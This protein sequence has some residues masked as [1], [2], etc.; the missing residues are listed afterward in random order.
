MFALL[1]ALVLTLGLS[2]VSK[3]QTGPTLPPGFN[4]SEVTSG[5]AAADAMA[6]A[7]DGRIFVIEKRGTVRVIKNG[8]LLSALFASFSARTERERGM[9]GIALDPDFATNHY[10]YLRYTK[11]TVTDGTC[12]HILSR[13]TANG[14][15]M[16]AGSEKV[17]VDFGDCQGV[18]GHNAGTIQ[19]GTDGKLYTSMGDQGCC[20]QYAQSLTTVFGKV[21]RLNLDGTIPTDNPFYN[22]TTGINRAIWAYGFR[23]PFAFA[24][25]PGTSRMYINDVG[26]ASWEEVDA[27][28]AGADYG[29]PTCEGPCTSSHP[30]FTE[31]IYAYP[32]T[33]GCSI[34][35]GLFYNPTTVSYP[36]QYVGKYFF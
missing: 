15:V 24:F 36:S 19:F 21:L 17:I 34:T 18:G 25:Q 22:T 8:A 16:L 32:H 31:P 11:G 3:A 12:R 30:E 5:M 26:E 9:I 2:S 7:P 10:I 1:G 35:G 28:Q 4:D 33:E 27:G 20:S 23:N 14:D 6:F 29:W 13:V